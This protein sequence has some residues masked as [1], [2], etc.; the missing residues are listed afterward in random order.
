MLH[1]SC[2]WV[3]NYMALLLE[4]SMWLDRYSE[5]HIAYCIQCI[6]LLHSSSCRSSSLLVSSPLTPPF[7]QYYFALQLIAMTHP[8]PNWYF[9]NCLHPFLGLHSMVHSL[10]FTLSHTL[11]I[12]LYYLQ[13]LY[14]FFIKLTLL[15]KVEDFN[16]MAIN[17]IVID[18]SR[19]PFK[20]KF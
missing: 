20:K 9:K 10:G 17:E 1:I 8:N 7:L 16:H 15:L 19:H 14:Y 2:V 3:C 11:F 13:L 12:K 6:S 4:K 5:D 18:F